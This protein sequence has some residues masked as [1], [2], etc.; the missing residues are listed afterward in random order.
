MRWLAY[1]Y[2]IV[3]ATLKYQAIEQL[4]AAVPDPGCPVSAV[5][6]PEQGEEA[7]PGPAS[8]VHCVRV[9]RLIT[10][11]TSVQCTN[12]IALVVERQ[13]PSRG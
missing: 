2:L 9:A 1:N 10:Q 6:E 13:A 3:K 4:A 11:K 12:P 8:L 7:K 5:D